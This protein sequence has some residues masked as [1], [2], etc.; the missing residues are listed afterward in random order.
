M[1]ASE[2]PPAARARTG[3]AGLD[4]MLGGG[5]PRGHV[6]LVTGLPGTG[7]TCLALQF[8]LAGVKQGEK[9]IFL[10]LEEDGAALVRGVEDMAEGKGKLAETELKAAEAGQPTAI[11]A[12]LLRPFAG[13]QAGDVELS[14]AQP[15]I[16][17]EPIAEFFARLDQGEMFERAK[18]YDEAE[19]AYRALI[20][21]GDPG[22]L[23]SLRLGEMLERRGHPR[24]AAAGIS[25]NRRKL[26]SL[27]ERGRKRQV[28]AAPAQQPP[29]G[30]T[31]STVSAAPS[32]PRRSGMSPPRRRRR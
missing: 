30:R 26:R 32:P 21:K 22:G 1:S 13:A 28:V 11:A 5:I 3:I 8:L 15:V 2:N 18:R 16:N 14:I 6:V 9:G 23:A 24:Q 20:A 4:E 10:S 31:T 25:G 19:T 29:A 12:A 7:K 17:N 27:G